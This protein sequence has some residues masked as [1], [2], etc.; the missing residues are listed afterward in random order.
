VYTRQTQI[1]HSVQNLFVG[2]SVVAL[3]P[4]LRV[5]GVLLL[6]AKAAGTMY[7]VGALVP[8]GIPLVLGLNK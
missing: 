2:Q 1:E 8:S 3:L 6:L 4:L 5:M 7:G